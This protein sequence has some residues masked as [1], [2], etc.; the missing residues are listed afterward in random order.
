MNTRQATLT[1]AAAAGLAFL[2]APA[3]CAQSTETT[4]TEG[5]G[6]FT[7]SATAGYQKRDRAVDSA[8]TTT[9][10]G[11]YLLDTAFG[12]REKGH[13]VEAGYTYFYNKCRTTD[14]AGPAIGVE[15][16]SGNVDVDAV[17]GNYS[18]TFSPGIRKLD[19]YLG[20]GYGRYR[21]SINGLTTPS[22][23]T[24]PAEWGGPVIVYAKSSWTNAYQLR[25]GVKF[26]PSEGWDILAGYR[27]FD[28]STMDIKLADGSVIH[29]ECTIHAFEATLR[30]SF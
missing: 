1:L 15:P 17:M 4:E 30:F 26:S 16:S 9:F 22:L 24:L 19:V 20:G 14:P 23:R 6:A 10:K 11:G 12:Y 2:T 28:G 25:G 18:Y 5:A 8:G 7:V 13:H 3:L 29:P 21:V 27:F